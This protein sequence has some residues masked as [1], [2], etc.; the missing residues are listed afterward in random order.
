MTQ[1]SLISDIPEKA[2]ILAKMQAPLRRIGI[3][4]DVAGLVAFLFTPTASYI[5]GQNFR[6]CGGSVMV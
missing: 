5:T 2:R 6:V 1:T 3:P 4:E